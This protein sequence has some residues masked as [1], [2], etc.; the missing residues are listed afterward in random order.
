MSVTQ[1]KLSKVQ[2]DAK[3]IY[4]P[5]KTHALITQNLK[6]LTKQKL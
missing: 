5:R 2:S 3:I 6:G 4:E 1:G